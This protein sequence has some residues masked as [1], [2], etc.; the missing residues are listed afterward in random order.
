[1]TDSA[2]VKIRYVDASALIKLVIDEPDGLLIRDFFNRNTNF[3]VTS[4]CLA[5]ALGRI[6]GLWKKGKKG[7][8]RLTTDEYFL[9]TRGLIIDAWGGRLAVD[10]LGLLDPKVHGDVEQMARR[11]HLDLSDAL[12]LLTIKRGRYS[13]FVGDSASVLITADGPLATAA[14]A[15][16]IRAWNCI[17]GP[18][19]SWA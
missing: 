10:D 16:G 2:S 3:C 6:K 13:V 15:E 8:K 1:M 18:A 17:V 12:Q 9:A 14:T 11:Y 5:E 19:P 4:L 7:G